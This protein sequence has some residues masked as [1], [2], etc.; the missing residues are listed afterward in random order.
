MVVQHY[1]HAF[2]LLSARVFIERRPPYGPLP[3]YLYIYT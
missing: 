2:A 1:A 3:I